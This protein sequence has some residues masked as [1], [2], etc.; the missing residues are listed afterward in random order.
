MFLSSI[1]DRTAHMPIATEKRRL[2]IERLALR[3]GVS[4]DYLDKKRL[5]QLCQHP[6]AH[7]GFV[8]ECS[9]LPTL[10]LESSLWNE[11]EKPFSQPS[12]ILCVASVQ[13]EENLGSLVRSASFFGFSG[14][15]VPSV[16]SAPLSPLVSKISRFGENA[17]TDDI[18]YMVFRSGALE[19]TNVIICPLSSF[20]DHAAENGVDHAII[21]LDASDPR[22]CIP[23]SSLPPWNSDSAQS[24]TPSS[25][26]QALQRRHLFVIVGNEHDGIPNTLL[27]RC[28]LRVFIDQCHPTMEQKPLLDS[29]NVG[30][31]FSAAAMWL[32]I[33]RKW[34]SS[35]KN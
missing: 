3:Q 23:L 19:Q 35:N 33:T 13:N 26:S 18:S 9:S 25:A 17:N 29:L 2:D 32:S 34:V 28:H 16:K 24:A 22:Q 4:V 27:K 15:V 5:D 12:M 8:L 21:G 11:A 20:F 1:S 31:A 6:N 14:V 7:G 10:N 30:S